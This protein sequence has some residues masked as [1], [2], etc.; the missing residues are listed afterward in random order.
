MIDRWRFSRGTNLIN[1]ISKI[2]WILFLISLPVSS[3]PFFPGG[4][5]G[6]TLVRPLSI[7]PLII[8][9]VLVILPRFIT[10]PLPKT[11]LS[12]LPFVVVALISS[13]LATLQGIESLQ[14][15]SAS[16][17]SFRALVTLGVGVAIYLSVTLWPENDDDLKFS[18]R[19][20]YI[21]FLIALF[22]GT[23]Q[24]IY[25]VYFSPRW[26]DLLSAA[27]KYI[28]IRKL[29]TNRVSGLTYEPNWFA[30]QISFL[31]LPWL[32]ASVLSG[33]S[34]FKWRWRWV[35][36]ELLL[37]GWA[38]AIIPFTF[39]RAGLLVMMFL[40]VV[41][42]VFFRTSKEKEQGK[43]AKGKFPWRR[44]IEAAILLTVL[45]A[46]IFIAGSRNDF[47]ARIWDYWER[48]P[49]EGY[50][51]YFVN[52]FEYLG[53]GARF[54]YMETAY[55]IF[56]QH[57]LL[58]VGLGNYVFHFN[59]NLADRP[60]AVVPEVLRLVVPESVGGRLIT[61]KNLII[62]IMAETGILGL[63]TFLAFIMAILGSAL[64][65]WFS[66]NKEVKFWGIGG[67]LGIIAFGLIAFSFDSFAIPNMWVVFGLITAAMR[68]ARRK[69][70]SSGLLG[71]I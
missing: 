23:L 46:I 6:G 51:S 27:Q 17:R 38:L 13:L 31:L 40:L 53:F 5:G 71:E 52:Y 15:I 36:I 68:L 47:F 18:L 66:H 59:E 22:W 43:G 34:V 9:V 25:V 21:G 48:A 14:G 45:A 30:D 7:Y 4:V 56:D 39:S 24:T 19:W 50:I 44:I 32:L 29:F 65:L 1:S 8:L 64:Y 63:S 37:L 69:S 12:F 54:T 28:S 49:S 41:G 11:V 26:F 20:L 62:R 3:F 2:C 70:I 16:A 10:K 33:Y 60:L 61:P 57:P 58:G 35:T 55:K 67:L 42:L